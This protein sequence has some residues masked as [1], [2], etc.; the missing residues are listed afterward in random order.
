[1]KL[2]L[3]GYGGHAKEVAAQIGEKVIFFVDDEYSNDITKPLSSFDPEKYH[4]MI[5]V[6]DSKARFDIVQKL[7]KETV[8]FTFVHPTALILDNNIE[9]GEGSFIG[10]YSILTTNIKLGKHALLNRANHIGHDC[11]IGD[12]FS[13]MPGAIVSGNVTIYDCV[14]MGTNSSIREKLNVHSL[15]IIGMNSCVV[16]N[17]NESGVYIGTPAKKIIK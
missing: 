3:Y 12:Y 2:A 1:M 8:Y 4:M 16:K 7:P 11:N 15:S 5:A 17:I 6:G 10:A 9:I 14:Y 13:A